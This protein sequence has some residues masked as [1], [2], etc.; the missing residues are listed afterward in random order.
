MASAP[1][2]ENYFPANQLNLGSQFGPQTLSFSAP[3]HPR[4]VK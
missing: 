2:T 3:K 4:L 1:R